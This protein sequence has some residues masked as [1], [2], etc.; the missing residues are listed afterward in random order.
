MSIS[1]KHIAVDKNVV[2]ELE[3]GGDSIAT[4]SRAIIKGNKN[5]MT[6]LYSLHCGIL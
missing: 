3:G 1:K 4:L 2:F 6:V 5:S